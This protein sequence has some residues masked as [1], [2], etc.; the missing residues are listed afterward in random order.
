MGLSVPQ[1][2]F[3]DSLKQDGFPLHWTMLDVLS[4]LL[5]WSPSNPQSNLGDFELSDFYVLAMVRR[6][7]ADARLQLDGL[8]SEEVDACRVRFVRQMILDKSGSD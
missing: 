3:L 4:H 6:G 2:S 5:D 8:S 7:E 1:Q